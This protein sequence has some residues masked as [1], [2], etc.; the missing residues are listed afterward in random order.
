MPAVEL[1]KL[2]AQI[3]ALAAKFS[4]PQAFCIALK[5][6][7]DLYSNRA[8]RPGMAVKPQPLLPSYR[9]SPLIMRELELELVKLSQAQPEQS[10]QTAEVLWQDGYIE[11][12]QIASTL[13]GT[14]PKGYEQAVIEK[15]RAW[16]DPAENFRILDTLYQNSTI[17]L[18][19]N[20]SLVPLSLAE[21]WMAS[22]DM[23]VQALG[24]RLLIPLVQDNRFENLPPVFRL[25]G[26]FVQNVLG[27]LQ[28]DIQSLLEALIRRSPA[29]TAYFLR[30]ALPAA[31]GPNTA[32]MIRRCLPLFDPEQQG[33][34]RAAIRANIP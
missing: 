18:R 10:L 27:P 23:Q 4:E 7:L 11:T 31:S 28:A 14:V 13:L 22:S 24:L 1:L 5:N 29:E 3:R 6:F 25:L 2:R 12:R 32:R 16:S 17:S 19:Q 33:I 30:Q 34:L 26:P 20:V 15:L 8:Y 21:E 9:V